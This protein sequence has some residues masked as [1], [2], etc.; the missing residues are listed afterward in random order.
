M[1]KFKQSNIL[2]LFIG[3][4]FVT[5]IYANHFNNSFHFDDSHTIVNN[6]AIREIG[7]LT[8]FFKDGTTFSSLPSN[9][10]YRPVVTTLNAID[11]YFS[12]TEKPEPLS[13]HI[14]IFISY[15]CT[16]LLLF[17]MLKHIL[18]VSGH[19]LYSNVIALLGTFWFWFHTANAE[20]INYIIARSDSFST[21]ML[22]LAFGIYLRFPGI[23]KYHLYFLPV[24]LGFLAKE[25][26]ILF[27]PLLFLYKLF[28]EA[29]LSLKDGFRYFGKS[30]RILKEMAVPIV[31]ALVV[32]LVYRQMT[33]K[34]WTPGGVDSSMYIATQPYVILHYFKNF[35]LPLHLVVDTDWTVVSSYTDPKVIMGCLFL[36]VS[37][38]TIWITAKRKATRP[39]A[40]GLLWFFIGLAPTSLIPF[41]E[42]MND[43]RTYFPYI[44]L[45]IAACTCL[46]LLA[47]RYSAAL[48]SSSRKVLVAAVA[49]LFLGAQAAGTYHRNEVWHTEESLWK[50]ATEKAPGNG[51]AWM[52]YGLSQMSIGNYAVAEDCFKKTMSLWPNYAYAFVNMGILKMATGHAAEA[53]QYFRTAMEKDA[54]SPEIY[55]YYADYLQKNNRY[56]EAAVLIAKGLQLS[57]NHQM[58]NQLLLNKP[59]RQPVAAAPQANTPEAYLEQSLAYYNAGQFIECIAAAE[60]SIALKPD[61]DLAYNNICAAYNQ[62]KEWD[63]AIAAGEKGK[64]INPGNE[65]IKGNLAVAYKRG[66]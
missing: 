35:L 12:G 56:N 30:L 28:F 57:P 43:H 34:T 36:L 33:P 38:I 61:Y 53:E 60:K 37:V 24:I 19:T 15:L 11:Y 46:S 29:D 6:M 64:A 58:L 9:Q 8:S 1:L 31:A 66:K 23:R 32:V 50:E 55:S 17:V 52:N 49:L 20:T 65:L 10:S 16:G 62:L 14:S 39:V 26:A 3:M 7:N 42:V 47:T 54:S 44:G 13:F 59:S 27:L 40:F 22:L 5:I 45:F 21:F 63:K 41:A 25:P 51:R 4:I 2:I 18:V 48:Q